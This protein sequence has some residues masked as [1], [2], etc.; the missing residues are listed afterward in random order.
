MISMIQDRMAKE[1]RAMPIRPLLLLIV[2]VALVFSGEQALCQAWTNDNGYD[3]VLFQYSTLDSLMS[4]IYEGTISFDELAEHGDFGLGTF[5]CLDG[6]MIA[7]DGDFYQIRADGVAYPVSDNMT[8][9]FAMVTRFDAD[10]TI[11]LHS[12]ENM[13]VLTQ[14]LEQILPTESLFAA[15]RIDG[16][17]PYI[18]AR[19]VYQ[20]EEPYPIL[21]DAVANE[22]IFELE[23][24]TGT[25]IGFWMPESASG[26]NIPGFHLHFITEDRTSGG[27]VKEIRIDGAEME[28][29]M[30]PTLLM[31]LP[32]YGSFLEM[33]PDWSM[34]QEMAEAVE[35]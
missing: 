26:I 1:G 20:Q 16:T 35:R 31:E 12:V 11:V 9:P 21:V 3:G 2:A 25:L 13:S 33:D 5:D 29:D 6:E 28:I 10:Q 27:H 24:V 30:L 7:L 15:I 17:F 8:T 34:T 23:N 19:S 32:T 14:M 4:G 22:S 18:K